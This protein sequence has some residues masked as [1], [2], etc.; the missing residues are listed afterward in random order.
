MCLTLIVC[1][2]MKDKC[3]YESCEQHGTVQHIT[4]VCLTVLLIGSSVP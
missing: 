2:E 3:I 4:A 1:C